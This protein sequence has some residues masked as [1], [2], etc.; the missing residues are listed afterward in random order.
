MKAKT[1]RYQSTD[2]IPELHKG[3]AS[4]LQASIFIIVQL[5]T[6]FRHLSRKTQHFI[7]KRVYRV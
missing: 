6:I 5:L 2:I 3:L 7:L 1:L 4:K